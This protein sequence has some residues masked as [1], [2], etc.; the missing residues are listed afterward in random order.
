MKRV[1][2]KK[3]IQDRCEKQKRTI[4]GKIKSDVIENENSV[5]ATPR[6]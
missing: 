2:K 3:K 5:G 4:Q 6:T 1:N